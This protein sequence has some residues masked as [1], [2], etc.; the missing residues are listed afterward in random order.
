MAH[1]QEGQS[2]SH[3][4]FQDD[5]RS[6]SAL[7]EIPQANRSDGTPVIAGHPVRPHP[8]VIVILFEKNNGRNHAEEAMTKER[9]SPR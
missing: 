6:V 8:L 4:E 3:R 9:D 2:Q 5:L 1:H 7:T